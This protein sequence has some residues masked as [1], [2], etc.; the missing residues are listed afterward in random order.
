MERVKGLGPLGDGARVLIV[1]GGPGGAVC[2]LAL[3]RGARARNRRI[4]VVILTPTQA[5]ARCQ[6][7]GVLSPP[8]QR[9]LR[10]QLDVVLPS[11][12]LKSPVAAYALHGDSGCLRFPLDDEGAEGTFASPRADLDAFLLNAAEA[13]GAQV[14]QT[15][16]EDSEFRCGQVAVQSEAGWFAG[17]VLVGAFGLEPTLGLSLARR[18]GYTPPPHLESVVV[19]VY[20]TR[21]T[22]AHVLVENTVHA[23][24]P[25]LNSLEFGALIPRVDHVSVVVAGA[26][27]DNAASEAFLALP[28]VRDL[29]GTEYVTAEH[30]R[31]TFPNGLAQHAYADRFVC[32]G[33][34][35]GLVRPF[36]GKGIYAACLTG[37]RAARSMLD[38]GISRDAFR[39]YIADC[40]DLVLDVQFGRL[41]RL[42]ALLLAKRLSLD[43]VLARAQTDESLRRALFLAV[44]GH[45]S[46]RDIV[47]LG[48]RPKTA[49]GLLGVSARYAWFQDK[50]AV[51]ARIDAV[52]PRVAA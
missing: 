12:L 11:E 7:V 20:P 24:L 37:I 28:A 6:S 15:R 8:F 2:A 5:R 51:R 22:T 38:L 1:G 10:E 52:K 3:L 27:V 19:N 23:F 47:W 50:P 39:A 16:V 43:P 26:R 30:V 33:D 46:S 45:G 21:G 32:I 34:S 25:K 13:A 49:L 31:G 18:V 42:L 17:D 35:A 29:V 9:V 40:H 41:V 36:K 48:A 4:E 44:S 14:V